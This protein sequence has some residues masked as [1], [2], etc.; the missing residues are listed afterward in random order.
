MLNVWPND[1]VRVTYIDAFDGTN[2]NVVKTD[3][4]LIPAET[5]EPVVPAPSDDSSGCSC[6][7]NPDGSV[8]PI[9]PAAVL[10]ALG[11]LGFRR[12]ENRGK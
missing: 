12:W 7:T 8:D 2:S 9:L 5:L 3:D 10:F 11:Y 1:Y 6:S 4:V